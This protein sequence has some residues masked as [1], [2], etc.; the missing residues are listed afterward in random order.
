METVIGLKRPQSHVSAS[1]EDAR[2]TLQQAARSL[3]QVEALLW[4]VSQHA[5]GERGSVSAVSRERI[6]IAV[7]ACQEL[8]HRSGAIAAASH[9]VL[10]GKDAA[11]RIYEPSL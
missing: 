11:A 6:A 3:V 2:I 5:Y 10:F 1:A 9:T 7:G 4:L 8:A